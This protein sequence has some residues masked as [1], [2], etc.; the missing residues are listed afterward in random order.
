MPGV[1]LYQVAPLNPGENV[2]PPNNAETR[3]ESPALLQ[4]C[5]GNGHQCDSHAQ[6]YDKSEGYCCVCQPGYYGNG[7]SCLANDLPMRV[8]GT[9][10]GQINGVP[11]DEEAKLQTY[12][13]TTDT[14][15][16][17]TIN[18][19]KEELA[20]QLRVVLPLVTTVGWLFAKPYNGAVNGYQLT[21]GQ[22]EHISRLQFDSG[23]TLL[24][25]QIFEGLNYWDQLTVKIELNGSV[26]DVGGEPKINVPDYTDEY[27]FVR[28]GELY[29]VHEHTLELVEGQ[30]LVIINVEQHIF[31]TSCLRDDDVDP[32]DSTVLQKVSKI[33][34]DYL[35]REEALRTSAVSKIGV[36]PDSN[37]CNDGSAQ[38]GEDA[39]CVPEDD[40]YHC[41][42]RH[43]YAAQLD[44]QGAQICVDLDECALGTHV[45]D[46]HAFCSNS[47]GGFTCVCLE[48]YEGN[49][50]RCLS[51]NT[52]DNIEYSTPESTDYWPGYLP[53]EPQQP[54]Q[55]E[56]P[57]QPEEQPQ[58]P[59][60]PQQPDETQEA[61]QPEQ[62]RDPH[63]DECSVSKIKWVAE[64]NLIRQYFPFFTTPF[65]LL[66]IR[67]ISVT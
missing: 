52:A 6:C 41:E 16:Y 18:P 22:Y 47:P 45:C 2:L 38:C 62:P 10:S 21:G 64:G 3:T 23:E 43:G 37:A 48:G 9:L 67:F 25:K 59:E 32:T 66:M 8:T 20:N 24:V 12:V 26:P 7:R 61:E 58:Q 17:T 53:Q 15:S 44:E 36:K 39:I 33:T 55:P 28:P 4:S 30:G 63:Y 14:R 57:Q 40:T 27:R 35:P 49:G 19:V 56:Q 1:W 31:Y 42:C 60:E 46:E 11:V 29:S 50:Y 54:E 13:V 5:S 65:F 34:L 51:N